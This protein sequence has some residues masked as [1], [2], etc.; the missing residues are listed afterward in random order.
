[1]KKSK[2]SFEDEL[3]ETLRLYVQVSNEVIFLIK[4]P[5]IRNTRYLPLK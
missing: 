5:P 3:A 4:T 2:A 1:M